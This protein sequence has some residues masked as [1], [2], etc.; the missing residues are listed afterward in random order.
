MLWLLSALCRDAE[1]EGAEAGGTDGPSFCKPKVRG[2]NPS[3]GTNIINATA[4]L[5]LA[6]AACSGPAIVES[7]TT[8][9]TVRYSGVDG[10]DDATRLAQKACA[11]H[12]KTARLRKSAN[13]GLA[14]RYGHFDCI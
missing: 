10:I 12:G 11:I 7:S 13:L 6:V 5:V 4:F 3:P 14:E 1:R 8:A 2:S 9:V